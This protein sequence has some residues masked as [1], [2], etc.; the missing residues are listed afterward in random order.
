MSPFI[1]RAEQFVAAAA[2]RSVRIFSRAE[3]LQKLTPDGFTFASGA[4][5]PLLCGK[6][7]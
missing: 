5:I 6:E 3:N 4:S 2:S 7:L 1:F